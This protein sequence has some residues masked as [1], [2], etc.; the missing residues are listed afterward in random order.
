ML[1]VLAVT[2][3]WLLKDARKEAPVSVGNRPADRF[4]LDY[5]RVGG[6]PAGA[7]I[8]QPQGAEIII[9]WAEKAP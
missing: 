3:F 6:Q 9:V 1:L 7:Y 5:I 2:G 8:Y 4:E